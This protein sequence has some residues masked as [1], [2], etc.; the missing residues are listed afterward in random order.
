M[1]FETKKSTENGVEW[2]QEGKRKT[3]ETAYA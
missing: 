1:K 2:R 3:K